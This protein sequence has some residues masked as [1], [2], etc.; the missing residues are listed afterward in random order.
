[1]PTSLSET[2]L[3]MRVAVSCLKWGNRRQ[4]KKEG[5]R[6]FSARLFHGSQQNRLGSNHRRRARGG[7]GHASSR[8]FRRGRAQQHRQHRQPRIL[9]AQVQ[10]WQ[11]ASWHL[12]SK[13]SGG[14]CSPRCIFVRT[15]VRAPGCA[16]HEARGAHKQRFESGH[17]KRNSIG[18][19]LTWRY[20][21][22]VRL[23]LMLELPRP[24]LR[25]R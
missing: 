10:K 12:F 15:H 8:Q 5:R 2:R 17:S 13:H 25:A 7:L 11:E 6:A 20:G 18:R 24:H 14:R 3:I 4:H 22:L 9:R 16:Q 19:L 21:L 1:M 23:L